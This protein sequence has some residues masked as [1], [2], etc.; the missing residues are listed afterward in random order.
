M[1][2]TIPSGIKRR[3]LLST[4]ALFP[5]LA[6][7]I[8]TAQ[9]AKPA[10]ASAFS[11]AVY[12]DSRSMMYLPYRSDQE[13][14]ARQLMVDIFSLVLPEKISEEVVKKEVKLIYDPAT[15]ELTQIVMP[16]ETRSE[17]TTLTLDKAHRSFRRGR[18]A[19]PRGAPH[20]V[21]AA[22]RRVGRP[23]G[24]EGRQ[25]RAGEVRSQHRGHGRGGQAGPDANSWP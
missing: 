16:F 22:G 2:P 21:P 8:A 11:F 15:K 18:K 9:K 7:Q 17:V 5:A 19:A 12:G 1:K 14:D 20:D 4:L 3:V 24:R 6:P 10:A 25:E 13:A 23:R